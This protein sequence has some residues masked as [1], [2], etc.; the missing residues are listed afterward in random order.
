MVQP[1]FAKGYTLILSEEGRKEKTITLIKGLRSIK[2]VNL[3]VK[4]LILSLK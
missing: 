1:T 2:N 4:G 3:L